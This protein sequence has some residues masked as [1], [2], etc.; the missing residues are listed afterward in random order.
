MMRPGEPPTKDA[1][2]NLF[3]NLFFSPDRY[4]L[5]AVGR[6][7]FNRRVGRENSQGPSILID[8]VFFIN[9]LEASLKPK[10]DKD[11][12]EV[13]KIDPELR[14]VPVLADKSD[15]DKI[16]WGELKQILHDAGSDIAYVMKTL[17]NIRNG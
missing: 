5:S 14:S 10:D 1:A 12:I 11:V 17:V 7:K 6:M 3:K 4:D 15:E 16:G 13:A 2:E 8:P 9:K